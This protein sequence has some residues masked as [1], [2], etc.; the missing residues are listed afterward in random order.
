MGGSACRKFA[1][2]SLALS[3]HRLAVPCK[4]L[5]CARARAGG[6]RV[7]TVI[8]DC[9]FSDGCSPCLLTAPLADVT[10]RVLLRVLRLGR[11]EGC[12]RGAR[13]FSGRPFRP[14]WSG[15]EK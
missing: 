5:Q 13:A 6:T 10:A 1:Q 14:S 11:F 7:A 4:V 8:S 9:F 3:M 12:R 15:L 2:V